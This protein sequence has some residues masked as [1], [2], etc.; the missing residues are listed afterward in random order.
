MNFTF[1]WRSTLIF[2]AA[3]IGA[4]TVAYLTDRPIAGLPVLLVAIY[5]LS[6][7]P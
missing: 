7:K 2:V 3:L 1:T 6:R 4:T 5:Y